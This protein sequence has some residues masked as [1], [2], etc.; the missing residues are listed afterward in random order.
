MQVTAQQVMALRERTGAGVME[1]RR[2]LLDAGGDMDRA[3][4]L[5]RQRGLER[6]EQKAG[7][8]ARQGLIEAYIH[9]GGR[10][11]AM[12]E[13]N[14]ETDFVARTPQFRELAHELAMQVAAMNPSRIGDESPD[15][16]TAVESGTSLLDQPYIRDSSKTVRELIKEHIASFGE[17]IVVRRFARFELGA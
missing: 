16:E 13:L 6:A 11:G 8:E 17:N 1:C 14:C 5:L 15:G 7:R 2:A 12:V 9:A 4:E 3:A 10:I